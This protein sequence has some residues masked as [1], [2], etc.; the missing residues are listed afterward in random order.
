[1][2]YV[3]TADSVNGFPAYGN[4][5]SGSQGEKISQEKIL[6]YTKSFNNLFI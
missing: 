2:V 1:M 3:V 5:M 6:S 4:V